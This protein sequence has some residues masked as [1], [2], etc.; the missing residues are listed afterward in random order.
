M[1]N[2]NKSFKAVGIIPARY[3]SRRF[4]G[5]LLARL[6]EKSVIEEVYRRAETAKMLDGLLVATDDKRIQEAVLSFGGKAVLTSPRHQTGTERVAEASQ[7]LKTEI[8]VNIQGDEPFIRGEMID[9]IVKELL[10]EPQLTMVTLAKKIDGSSELTDPNTV[11]V[12]MDRQG[13]ACYFSRSPIPHHPAGA[14]VKAYKHIGLY[15][16]R[17]KFLSIISALP[18]GRLE[19]QERLEQLRVLEN[20]YKIKILE[21]KWDTIGIDTP[22]DLA[23]ARR[24]IEKV[25]GEC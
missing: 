5:K 23:K 10:R 3:A 11:K 16:Y 7:N 13:Y 20:G 15:G 19:K 22:E 17:K 18:R 14:P 21:T 12:V 4:P 2:I 24:Y 9:R 1:L 25:S 8:V 6:G